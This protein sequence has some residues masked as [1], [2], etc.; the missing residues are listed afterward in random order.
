MCANATQA[1]YHSWLGSDHD[2]AMDIAT[3]KTVLGDFNDTKF[4]YHGVTTRFFRRDGKFMVNTEGPD[5][6]HHD[7][8]VK[9]TFGVRPLQQY[10]VKFPDGRVQVLRESWDVENK[11]W[12][13]RH[14]ARCDERADP[15]G[16]PAPLDRHRP[17]LEHHVRR[18]PF[19]ERAQKLRSENE[20]V[21]H[22]VAGNQR[23]L[24][25]VPRAGQRARRISPKSWSPFWD[26]NI[27]YGL[28]NLK[29]KNLTTQIETCAKCHARRYQVHEDFR[30]GR[31]FLDY[32][33][34]VLLASGVYQPDG[35]ILDEVYE[36]GSFLQSK[37]HANHVRCTDCHDPHSLKLKFA[38]NALCTQCHEAHNPAKYDYA[39][40]PSSPGR[41]D[42]RPMH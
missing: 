24:R 13:L 25:G 20:H 28:P 4:E 7:Y 40:P 34:P 15:A 27:G 22:V 31:P 2:R 12:F 38:G 35:Q 5:G 19:D 37:M 6:K 10:M 16:R 39:R 23:Q 33:E 17:E 32:Y 30:P 1:Q 11:K 29:D 42:R 41:L 21:Q 8:E 14:A 9:Y 36:Y 18:L 3:E 26:R